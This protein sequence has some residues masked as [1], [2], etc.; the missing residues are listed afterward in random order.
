MQKYR[1]N[2]RYWWHRSNLLFLIGF[3]ELEPS[4]I[5][6]L[7]SHVI[8]AGWQ[9][10]QPTKLIPIFLALSPL[11][12]WAPEIQGI[13]DRANLGWICQSQVYPRQ[14]TIRPWLR[15]FLIHEPQELNFPQNDNPRGAK[16]TLC[17]V[18]EDT[19]HL[20][21]EQNEACGSSEWSSFSLRHSGGVKKWRAVQ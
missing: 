10:F 13:R 15:N 14:S 9:V 2:R 1:R 19:L 6:R 5:C 16:G 21:Y 12:H 20:L 11:S 8:R 17:G 18:G 7:F 3:H 4:C